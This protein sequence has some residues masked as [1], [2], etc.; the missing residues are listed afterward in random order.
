MEKNEV[1]TLTIAW[2]VM[3]HQRMMNNMALS[4]QEGALF[5]VNVNI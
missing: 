3:M 2:I 4:G 1:R 5:L